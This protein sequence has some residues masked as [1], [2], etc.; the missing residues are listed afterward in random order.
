MREGFNKTA[1]QTQT[2]A[3]CGKC[4]APFINGICKCDRIVIV[5]RRG[6][7]LC[8]AL[9]MLAFPAY[10]ETVTVKVSATVVSIGGVTEEGQYVVEPQQVD[11]QSEQ[12]HGEIEQIVSY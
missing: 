12:E 9:M 11:V 3:L 10:A 7:G 6:V 8:L 4:K 2:Q 5:R 1:T